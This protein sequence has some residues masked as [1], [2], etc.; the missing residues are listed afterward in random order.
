MLNEY[1]SS[2][3]LTTEKRYFKLSGCRYISKDE[4]VKIMQPTELTQLRVNNQY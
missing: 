3:K 4:Y 1:I 2:Q